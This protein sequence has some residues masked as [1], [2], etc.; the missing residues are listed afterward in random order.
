MSER[1]AKTSTETF[2]PITLNRASLGEAAYVFA[3][4]NAAPGSPNHIAYPP[5]EDIIVNQQPVGKEISARLKVKIVEE[6]QDGFLVETKDGGNVVRW[7]VNREG[8]I[9]PAK[10]EPVFNY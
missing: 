9:I 4:I 10:L 8:K 2:V 3:V 7:K 5:R 1:L 6:N